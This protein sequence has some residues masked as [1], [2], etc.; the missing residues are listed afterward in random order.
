MGA[1][2]RILASATLAALCLL[3]PD[4][5]QARPGLRGGACVDPCSGPG[6]MPCPPC[7]PRV[8]PTESEFHAQLQRF[9]RE[10]DA[11]A[12]AIR[13]RTDSDPSYAGSARYQADRAT[14]LEI[15]QMASNLIAIERG[16]AA[17][18]PE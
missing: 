5:L 14:Y 3:S 7:P 9:I 4:V 12:A 18:G 11:F 1:G 2:M 13:A 16:V 6:G 15:K 8:G 10:R 17:A